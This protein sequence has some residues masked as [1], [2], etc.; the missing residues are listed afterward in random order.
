MSKTRTSIRRYKCILAGCVLS[1]WLLA[2]PATVF[3]SIGVGVGTGIIDVSDKL[4]AGGIYNLPAVVVYNTGTETATYSMSLTLNETQEQ[5]KP[6]PAWFSFSP[7]EFQLEPGRSQTVTPTLSLPVRIEPGSY[8]GYLEAHP[9]ETTEQGTTRV[10]VAAATILRFDVE[11]SNL[12]WAIL[13]RIRSLYRQAEPWSHVAV[14]VVVAVI[15]L[16]IN[17]RYLHI[18]IKITRSGKSKRESKSD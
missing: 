2:I 9:V 5:L 13:Y 17:K 3:A 6:N 15:I 18:N 12:F 7:I 11:A 16:L 8:Y 10:G 14:G 4:R 1:L